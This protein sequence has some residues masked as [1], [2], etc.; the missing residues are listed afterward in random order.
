MLKLPNAP[1]ARIER[2]KVLN[3][4][5]STSHPDGR[6]KAAFFS[7][8]GFEKEQWQSFVAALRDHGAN[9]EITEMIVSNYGTRYSVDGIIETP[10][11]RNP[12]VRTVWIID[13]ADN[14]PQLVTAYPLRREDARRT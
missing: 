12:Y 11:G 14:A 13:T 2:A 5:L 4:L 7:R 10:D 1:Q 8:F 9:N 3:Y 6:S